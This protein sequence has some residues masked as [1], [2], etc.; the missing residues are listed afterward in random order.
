MNDLITNGKEIKHRIISEINQ[1]KDS[2]YLAM[3]WFTDRDIANAIISAKNRGVNVEII[4]SSNASNETVKKMFQLA[5]INVHAFETGDERGNMHHRFCLIDGKISISGSYNYSYNASNNNVESIHVSDNH[6]TYNQLIT[7]FERLQYKIDHNLDLNDP[8]EQTYGAQNG[9]PS[10]PSHITSFSAQINNLI[11]ASAHL[12]FNKY[13][14]RGYECS[15]HSKGN[16][17]TY[18]AE[19]SHIREDIRALAADDSLGSI[20]NILKSNIR[21]AYQRKR[22]DIEA[23]SDQKLEMIRRKYELDKQHTNEEIKNLNDKKTLLET[24]DPTTGEKGIFQVNSELE[25]VKLEKAD[26]EESTPVRKFWTVGT[27]L[28]LIGLLILCFYLSL[29]FASAFYKVFFEEKQ[30]QDMFTAGLKP[31]IPPLV[32]A[33][34]IVKIFKQ[35]G[36]FF[37]IMAMLFFLIPILLSNLNLLG[38]QNRTVNGLGFWTGVL[39]FDVIVAIVVAHNIDRIRSLIAGKESQLG[40]WEVFNTGEFWMIFVFG[41]LP[42]IITHFLIQLISKNYNQ[43]QIAIIDAEKHRKIQ[44]LNKKEIEFNSMKLQIQQKIS[45]IKDQ[46]NEKRKEIQRI[47]NELEYERSQIEQRGIAIIR[48]LTEIYDDFYGRIESGYIFTNDILE[49]AI[50]AF[51]AGFIRYLPEYYAESEVST[52]VQQLEPKGA[53]II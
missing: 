2:I 3:A 23:D 24:G 48:D 13:N 28:S 16:V 46:I 12:D 27:V 41:M 9:V 45:H 37:G 6:E 32:D 49:N 15:R 40:L 44:A 4:L 52:R 29:F 42:L 36:G 35:Q 8:M 47:E 51:R 38:S 20:K 25:R 43:S 7:E 17:E 50:A 31:D 21:D 10:T 26:L 14:V 53:N 39:V 1:A 11:Y 19:I 18:K 33:N 22:S 34:A 5:H 30:I